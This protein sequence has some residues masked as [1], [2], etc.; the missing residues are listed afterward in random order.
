MKAKTSVRLFNHTAVRARWDD[1]TISWWYVATDIIE[2]LAVSTDARRYW[3]TFKRRNPELSSFCRHL[4]GENV[5]HS[6]KCKDSMIAALVWVIW[7][8][9]LDPW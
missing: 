5:T 3:N 9:V 4:D 6:P 8:S 1:E 7:V 2:A